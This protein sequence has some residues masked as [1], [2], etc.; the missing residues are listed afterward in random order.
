MSVDQVEEVMEDQVTEA[1]QV[2]AQ[3]LE[4]LTPENS[5]DVVVFEAVIAEMIFGGDTAML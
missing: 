1:N 4:G 3:E 5:V 2:L